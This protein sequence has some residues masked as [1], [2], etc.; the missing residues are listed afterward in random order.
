MR[1][2]KCDAISQYLLIDRIN[3]LTPENGQKPESQIRRS[4]WQSV[5]VHLVITP[6]NPSLWDHGGRFPS[7]R[8]SWPQLLRGMPPPDNA[9]KKLETP[10]QITPCGRYA[11]WG[12]VL[13]NIFGWFL[14]LQCD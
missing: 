6:V 14:I 5:S 8:F 3:P 10:I 9:M 12:E 13:I 7:V 11:Y 2:Q 4:L 1:K